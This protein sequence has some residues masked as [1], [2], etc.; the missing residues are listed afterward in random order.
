[1]LHL[2]KDHDKLTVINDQF[3][4]RIWTRT[5]TY[6]LDND[7]PFGTFTSCLL[8]NSYSQYDF[9]IKILKDKD[10]E[11]ASVDLSVYPAKAYRPCYSLMN[12]KKDEDTGSKIINLENRVEWSLWR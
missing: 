6:L 2:A 5:M 4:R 11:V 3:W 12:L 8:K 7:Q 9:T 1:M 10:V